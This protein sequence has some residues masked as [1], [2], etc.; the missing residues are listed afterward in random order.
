MYLTLAASQSSHQ[1]QD[2]SPSVL[3][4]RSVVTSLIALQLSYSD[5]TKATSA[6]TNL[7]AARR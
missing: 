6:V 7:A 2:H 4:V 5:A 3:E 1:A